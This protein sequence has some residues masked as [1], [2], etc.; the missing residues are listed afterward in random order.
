MFKNLLILI[1]FSFCLFLL[2][3]TTNISYE[4]KEIKEIQ[5]KN[6]LELEEN[7]SRDDAVFKYIQEFNTNIVQKVLI[8]EEVLGDLSQQKHT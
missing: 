2:D 7:K 3:K 8:L 1:L 6:N 4:L 5:L